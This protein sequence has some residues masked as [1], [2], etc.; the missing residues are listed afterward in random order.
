MSQLHTYE[1]TSIPSLLSALKQH[2]P[3]CLPLYRRLQF[4]HF[5]PGSRIYCSLEPL[6]AADLDHN[7]TGTQK[8]WLAAYVDRT[9]RPETEIFCFGSWESGEETLDNKEL[10][11]QACNLVKALVKEAQSCGLDSSEVYTSSSMFD[12]HM[13]NSH[14]AL[15]GAVHER[16][17]HLMVEIGVVA[18]GFPV[19]RE[20]ANNKWVFDMRA[21]SMSQEARLPEG[22]YW[23]EV[24]EQHFGLIKSRTQIPRMDRTMRLLPS[25]AVYPGGS[26]GD[27]EPVAWAFLGVDASLTT[28]HVEPEYRGK[29]LAKAVTAKLWSTCLPVFLNPEGHEETL[30]ETWAHADVLVDNAASNGVSKSL[31]GKLLYVDYW[32]RVDTSKA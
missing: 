9:R 20:I 25:V 32:M 21:T 30:S 11:A 10:R 15:F 18:D 22:L 17:A 5:T 28:L 8:P 16:T 14:I 31:G 7:D 6:E 19:G 27:A 26:A 24:Q 3:T 12:R 1:L 2:L 23:G 13:N 29:G 4:G